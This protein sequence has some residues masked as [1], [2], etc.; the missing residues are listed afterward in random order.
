MNPEASSLSTLVTPHAALATPER[1]LAVLVQ[2][3]AGFVNR[4]L[5]ILWRDRVA[6]DLAVQYAEACA[7]IE[8]NELA[9]LARLL[10]DEPELLEYRSDDDEGHQLLHFAARRASLA[11][12]GLLVEQGAPLDSPSG[13][14]RE[15]VFFPGATPLLVACEAGCEDA[16]LSLLTAG[17]D[18]NASLP[19]RRESALHLAAGQGMTALVEALIAAGADVDAMSGW[20]SFDD[21]LG[22][23]GGGSPLHAAA[24]SNCAAT[25][26]LLLKA[27][28]TRDAAGADLRTPLHYAAARG[29]VGVLEVLLAAG[30]E[31][32]AQEVCAF[33]GG[34]T[35]LSALHYAVVNGHLE[36]AAMLLCYGANPALIEPASGESAL[37]MALRSGNPLLPGVLQRALQGQPDAVYGP[38]DE[39]LVRCSPDDYAEQRDFLENL[40]VESPFSNRSLLVLSDWLAETLGPENRPHLARAYREWAGRSQT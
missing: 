37:E 1:Q 10:R 19:G 33:E 8:R 29:A 35:G 23:F 38:L 15:G 28:A 18:P 32:D 30:A 40:L 39:Q 11:A 24:L 13:H 3:A 17:A 27:G 5:A 6:G 4:G 34:T 12:L 31:P 26:F 36:A 25:A 7:L 2:D 9:P 16:A 21:Q 22:A 14:L 20:H